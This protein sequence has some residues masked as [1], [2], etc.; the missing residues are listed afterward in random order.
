M[1]ISKLEVREHRREVCEEI[2][3]CRL[4]QAADA[5]IAILE[6][7]ECSRIGRLMKKKQ[8]LGLIA[9]QVET[10]RRC[11]GVHELTTIA[12]RVVKVADD[13]FCRNP[14]NWKHIKM[15]CA[16][17][18]YYILWNP[19]GE[20][21]GIRL[22]T[23]KEYIRQQGKI[24]NATQGFADL[25]NERSDIIRKHGEEAAHLRLRLRDNNGREPQEKTL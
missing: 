7:H 16:A 18:G 5:V 4:E 22:G 10:N 9:T 17:Y 2:R 8:L 1:P 20:P 14:K 19:Y 12:N 23:L 25:H 13:A 6:D 3:R 11:R 15:Y 24:V 21:L